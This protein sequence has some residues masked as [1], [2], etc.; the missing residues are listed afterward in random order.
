MLSLVV[1]PEVDQSLWGWVP[2][3]TAL[4]VTDAVAAC[5]VTTQLKWPNDVLVNESKLAGILCEVVPTGLRPALVAGWGINVDQAVAELPNAASTSVRLSGGR[6][7]REVLVIE[8]LTAWEHWYTVWSTGQAES[9][10]EAYVARSSTLG[11]GVRV[12]LPDGSEIVGTARRLDANGHLV[13]DSGGVERVVTAADVVHL[14]PD[15]LRR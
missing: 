5:G 10:A 8:C 14:R 9:V 6:S 11:S 3:M 2:L 12:Q 1:E 4:A 15:G 7:S 13:V